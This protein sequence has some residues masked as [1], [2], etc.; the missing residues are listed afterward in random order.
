MDGA[1]HMFVYQAD[2]VIFEYNN[3]AKNQGIREI[4]SEAEEGKPGF[5]IDS[6]GNFYVG[7]EAFK[8]AFGEPEDQSEPE[9]ELVEQIE[10]EI[11]GDPGDLARQIRHRR[12]ARRHHRRT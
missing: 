12:R 7:E 1:G 9:E 5:A 3:E 8:P 10:E 2:E 6:E 4:K 11:E